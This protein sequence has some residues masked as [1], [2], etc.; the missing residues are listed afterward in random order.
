MAMSEILK[1]P[2]ESVSVQETEEC[3][4]LSRYHCS[5]VETC[6]GTMVGSYQSSSLRCCVLL[7]I[8]N[9]NPEGKLRRICPNSIRLCSCLLNAKCR[10]SKRLVHLAPRQCYALLDYT[11]R[12]LQRSFVVGPFH[13]V[14]RH[15]RVHGRFLLPYPDYQH[16]IKFL[17]SLI[18]LQSHSDPSA[19]SS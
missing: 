15:N 17:G 12:H 2:S 8:L 7:D 6:H 16:M 1:E 19:C 13:P 14:H 3:T 11:Y 4:A 10:L 5:K 9:N 18:I